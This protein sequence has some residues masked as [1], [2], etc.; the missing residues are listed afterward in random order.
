[1]AHITKNTTIY[2]LNSQGN[3][4]EIE[5]VMEAKVTNGGSNSHGSDEPEWFDVD[6]IVMSYPKTGRKV[7]AKLINTLSE[8]QMDILAEEALEA[9]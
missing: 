3:E 4:I 6:D 8:G 1:M 5:V 7:P 9:Y 2:V